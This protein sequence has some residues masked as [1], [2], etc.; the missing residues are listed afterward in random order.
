MVAFFRRVS[1]GKQREEKTVCDKTYP[2]SNQDPVV[3]PQFFPRYA[4]AVDAEPEKYRG[5]R[6]ETPMRAED[7]G[8][9]VVVGKPG[10]LVGCKR[11]GGHDYLR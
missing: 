9:A 8:A 6:R 3:P 11:R 2:G 7:G 4:L 1:R 10:D 5:Q